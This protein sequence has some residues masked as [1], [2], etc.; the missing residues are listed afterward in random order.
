M[1]SVKVIILALCLASCASPG[2]MTGTGY[3]VTA[4]RGRLFLW[5]RVESP[6]AADSFIYDKTGLKFETDSLIGNKLPYYD[7][8]N[9]DWYI[10][11]EKKDIYQ[12]REKGRKRWRAYDEQL[13]F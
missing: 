3:L 12:R 9:G 8:S 1:R 4:E 2:Q 6:S 13:N 10:Y 5:D 11:V 7:F